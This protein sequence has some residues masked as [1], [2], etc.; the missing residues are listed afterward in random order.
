MHESQVVL[1]G[2]R[3]LLLPT[4]LT[5][6]QDTFI[7]SLTSSLPRSVLGILTFGVDPDPNLC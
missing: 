3:E 7:A 1:T 2:Q 5:L 6:A 4:T